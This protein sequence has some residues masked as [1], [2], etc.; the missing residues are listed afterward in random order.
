VFV[1]DEM[2]LD[3]GYAIAR[4]RLMRLADG[5]TLLSTSEDAYDH[6]AAGLAKV[7]MPG[8]SKLVRVQ[9]RELTRT[10][11]SAALAIRWEATGPGGGLFPVLDADITLAPAGDA[12]DFGDAGDGATV[13][14][15]AGV[16]RPPLGA[17]GQAL[18]RALLHHIALATIRGFLAGLAARIAGQPSDHVAIQGGW[19]PRSGPSRPEVNT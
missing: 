8:L 17:L 7:G 11:G 4:E 9:V 12:G 1:G 2:R 5:G 18:D 3:V 6:A 10:E 13:L 16:Y 15:M 19:E 14:T